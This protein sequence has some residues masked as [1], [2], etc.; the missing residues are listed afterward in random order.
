M[1]QLRL[2][3]DLAWGLVFGRGPG[4]AWRR[5]ATN[6]TAFVA[7][8]TILVGGGV[9]AMF[10]AEQGRYATGLG[11][12]A[13]TNAPTDLLMLGAG[14][15]WRGQ[16]VD[17]VWIEPADESA[18][19]VLPRG[20]ARLPDP[21][22]AVV[23]PALAALVDDNPALRERYRVAAVLD[24]SGV[25]SGNDLVAYVRPSSPQLAALPQHLRIA[26][27]Q[28]SLGDDQSRGFAPP[29]TDLSP[30]H[31][32]AGELG[33]V[34]VPAIVLCMAGLAAKSSRRASRFELLRALGM[35][36]RMLRSLS[37]IECVLAVLPGAVLAIVL[38]SIAV[39]WLT[40]IPFTDRRVVPGDLSWPTIGYL[41]LVCGMALIAG[42]IGSIQPRRRAGSSPRPTLRRHQLT[43]WILLP[44]GMAGVTYAAMLL[45]DN[46]ADADL[47]LIGSGLAVVGAIAIVPALIRL[48][49]ALLGHLKDVSSF[50]AGRSLTW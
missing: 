1:I 20:I 26:G 44:L 25:T 27:F 42:A 14:D 40:T 3:L 48:T 28:G 37:A 23:S 49:G 24:W 13:T 11:T 16:D 5:M 50:L 43:S 12:V 47:A 39:P 8:L 45:V 15:A 4:Q 17:V 29:P 22:E 10:A 41:L 18:T 35:S 33:L 36:Q 46:S 30:A 19:P 6:G 7:A 21:G 2:F 32:V 31:I 38:W 9:A 34:I